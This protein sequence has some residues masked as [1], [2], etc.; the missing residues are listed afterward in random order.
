MRFSPYTHFHVLTIV[1]MG[2]EVRVELDACIDGDTVKMDGFSRSY[3]FFWLWVL[4]AFEILRTL[5]KKRACF[6]DDFAQ[7]VR[8]L[9]GQVVRLRVPFAKLELS[10]NPAPIG[11][12][13]SVSEVDS[14]NKDI[15]FH[16]EGQG[17][18]ARELIASFEAL[19]EAVKSTDVRKSIY[20]HD[21]FPGEHLPSRSG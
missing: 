17:F 16:I 21:Y 9:K 7:R 6:S 1:N 2:R 18:S 8:T 10:G 4:G 11:P 5:L 13:A 14:A 15:R 12:E 20:G 3:S 19:A